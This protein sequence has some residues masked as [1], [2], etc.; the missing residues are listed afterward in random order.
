MKKFIMVVIA[1]LYSFISVNMVF[2]VAD[3]WTQKADFG[4]AARYGAVGFSIGSKGYFG[5]GFIGA[6]A[7]ADWQK[8]DFWEYDQAANTWT[9]KADYGGGKR[10]EAAGFSIG[11]KGYIGMGNNGYASQKD[12]WEYDPI[13]NTWTQKADFGGTVRQGSVGFSIGNKG[14]FGTGDNGARQ[15]EFWEYD[16]EKDTWTQ[17]ADF[18]GEARMWATGF[19][20]GSKGYIGMGMTTYYND[21]NLLRDLIYKDF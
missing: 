15:K 4:G 2:A 9:Q 7:Y 21:D 19:S 14:Y 5:T 8:N 6:G 11:N 16:P 17:K 1:L 3:T 20:I 13:A 12:F 18:G 10:R